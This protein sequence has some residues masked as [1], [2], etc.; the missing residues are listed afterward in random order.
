MIEGAEVVQ[1]VEETS[2]PLLDDLD[3][4]TPAAGWSWEQ[5][6]YPQHYTHAGRP[7]ECCMR[8]AIIDVRWSPRSA[9][10]EEHD[11]R[12]IPPLRLGAAIDQTIAR[13]RLE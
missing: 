10:L 9:K 3:P 1:G 6:G 12:P 11:Q 4:S 2:W 7:P 5:R 13:E 8:K